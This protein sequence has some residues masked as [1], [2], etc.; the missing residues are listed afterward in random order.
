MTKIANGTVYKTKYNVKVTDDIYGWDS[1]DNGKIIRMDME[2]VAA[3][4]KTINGDSPTTIK[5]KSYFPS[6]W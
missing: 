4:I 2:A 1:D 3:L 6:G 5:T